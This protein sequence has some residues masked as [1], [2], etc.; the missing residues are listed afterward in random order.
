MAGIRKFYRLVHGSDPVIHA[1][2]PYETLARRPGTVAFVEVSRAGP[3]MPNLDNETGTVGVFELS[4]SFSP[5][6]GLTPV[7]VRAWNRIPRR[8][9]RLQRSGSGKKLGG[10]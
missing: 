8:S 9:D 4:V 1:Y 10:F 6:L 5:L 7:Y 2:V 3:T